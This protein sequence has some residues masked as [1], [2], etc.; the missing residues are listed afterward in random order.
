MDRRRCGLIEGDAGRYAKA[1]ARRMDR[2]GRLW[3]SKWHAGASTGAA[4]RDPGTDPG[5]RI[6]TKVGRSF[7]GGCGGYT[8]GVGGPARSAFARIGARLRAV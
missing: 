6:R 3:V 2:A 7:V 1:A 4:V 5:M 8:W